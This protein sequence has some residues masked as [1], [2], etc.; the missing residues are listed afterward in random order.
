MTEPINHGRIK[1]LGKLWSEETGD[2][3]L[4]VNICLTEPTC[5]TASVT[6]D[7]R[8]GLTKYIAVA[9]TIEEAINGAVELAYCGEVLGEDVRG[10]WPVTNPD[11]YP[12]KVMPPAT[13]FGKAKE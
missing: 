9:D 5:P 8:P 4:T 12:D 13:D 1:A 6:S 11:D 10:N 3:N 7:R 2:W